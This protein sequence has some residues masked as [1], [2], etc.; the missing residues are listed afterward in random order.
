MQDG[1]GLLSGTF[2]EVEA[3]GAA[4]LTA[5]GSVCDATRGRS[6]CVAARVHRCTAAP[7]PWKT[8]DGTRLDGIPSASR[9]IREGPVRAAIAAD[10]GSRS[11]FG[12]RAA[13]FRVRSA[14]RV[15]GRAAVSL[16][17]GRTGRFLSAGARP[18]AF[19]GRH[20]CV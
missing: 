14:A 19:S 10:L 17:G 7:I 2:A 13:T 4:R 6:R 16:C 20:C 11:R 9:G 18:I 1:L 3:A 15:G 5:V 12:A 8:H